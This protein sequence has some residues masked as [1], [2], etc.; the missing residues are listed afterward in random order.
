V[1]MRSCMRSL[2]RFIIIGGHGF[3]DS[4]SLCMAL[5]AWRVGCF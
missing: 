4:S 3:G 1:H 5:V 2:S